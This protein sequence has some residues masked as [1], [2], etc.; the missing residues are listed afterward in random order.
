M[1]HDD[2][3]KIGLFRLDC[4]GMS[5]NQRRTLLVNPNRRHGNDGRFVPCYGIVHE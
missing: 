5:T 3:Y 1:D 4:Y 2:E